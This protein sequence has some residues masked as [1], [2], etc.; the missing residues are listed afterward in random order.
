[1]G[2]LIR[3][4]LRSKPPMKPNAVSSRFYALVTDLRPQKIVPGDCMILCPWA[5]WRHIDAQVWNP[6]SRRPLILAS[7][8]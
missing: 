1:M 6:A 3:F 4:H 2:A 5:D 8:K 7:E